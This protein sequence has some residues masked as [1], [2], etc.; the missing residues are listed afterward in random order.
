MILD[1]LILIREGLHINQVRL[2]NQTRL[3][4]FFV[5]NMIDYTIL[6]SNEQTFIKHHNDFDINLCIKDISEMLKDKV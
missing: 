5:H 2:G 1:K 4:D 6:F 3:I